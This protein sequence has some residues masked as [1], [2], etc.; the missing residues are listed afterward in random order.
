MEVRLDRLKK[1]QIQCTDFANIFRRKLEE[2]KCSV[3]KHPTM[4]CA[5]Y[6]DPRLQEELTENE[7]RIAKMTLA[8][9]HERI[10]DLKAKHSANPEDDG[11][12]KPN[13]S[14]DEYFA[15]KRLHKSKE[16]SNCERSDFMQTLD[17]FQHS[18]QARDT[19][20]VLENSIIH[21]CEMRKSSNEKLY[22]VAQVIYAIPPSQAEVER[23]FSTLSF[24]FNDK[25]VKLAQQT[26]ENILLIKLNHEIASSVNQNDLEKLKASRPSLSAP[27]VKSAVHPNQNTTIDK[28]SKHHVLALK[29]K[30]SIALNQ[31]PREQQPQLEYSPQPI[32]RTSSIKM[33]RH[34]YRQSHIVP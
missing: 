30:P 23:S 1:N 15:E 20:F 9:L 31:K 12:E 3:L 8:N 2:R 5:I 18:L 17:T 34:H 10:I 14:L 19:R 33:D 25:R 6:L 11:E 16:N 4:L 32:V 22:D 21:F 24:V 28:R 7:V 13:S 26:L 29:S 27:A